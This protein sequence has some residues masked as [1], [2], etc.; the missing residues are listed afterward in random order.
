MSLSG[1]CE[2]LQKLAPQK[3]GLVFGSGNL[4]AKIMLI[5]EAPGK[6]EVLAGRPFVGRAGKNLDEFLAA[7]GLLREKLYL[8]NV[9]KFRPTRV[10]ERGSISNRPPTQQEI[11]LCMPCLKAELE[12][13]APELILTLGN[14]ALQALL[15]KEAK[16]GQCHGQSMPIGQGRAVFA[17]YHPASIIYNPKLRLTYMEDLSRLRAYLTRSDKSASIEELEREVE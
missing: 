12:A 15:G 5:G 11:A 14:V 2:R 17:L 3:G 6:E 16:I 9:V 1:Q 7:T 8:T 13:L 4:D 10:S